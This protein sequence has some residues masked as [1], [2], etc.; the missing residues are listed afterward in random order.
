MIPFAPHPQD[1]RIHLSE[2]D[3]RDFTRNGALCNPAGEIGPSEF[4]TIMRQE[5]HIFVQTRLTDFSN[6]R[7]EADMELTSVGAL[8]TVLSEVLLLAQEQRE[9]RREIMESFAQLRCSSPSSLS[10]QTTC[11]C[12]SSEASV[13]LEPNET[14]SF[15]SPAPRKSVRPP[16]KLE[17]ISKSEAVNEVFLSR[18]KIQLHDSYG[19]IEEDQHL[20]QPELENLLLSNDR[21]PAELGTWPVISAIDGAAMEM[22]EMVSGVCRQAAEISDYLASSPC[23]STVR[24]TKAAAL[25]RGRKRWPPARVVTSRQLQ[26]S[27][28]RGV[29]SGELGVQSGQKMSQESVG[30]AAFGKS[31]GEIG[32]R[33]DDSTHGD[34]HGQKCSFRS[35]TVGDT[36]QPQA[37]SSHLSLPTNAI[38][39]NLPA[40]ARPPA[41]LF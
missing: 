13:I 4:E 15:K 40:Q 3:F 36:K 31:S 29:S 5:I 26:P 9:T 8:K 10:A 34:I 28:L 41:I 17:Q 1:P 22:A 25:P 23:S 12:I 38:V 2:S 33:P 35:S 27:T 30:P 7:T 6:C 19:C 24:S 11:K 39:L 32:S 16:L 20:V 14:A 37:A 21:E 18:H